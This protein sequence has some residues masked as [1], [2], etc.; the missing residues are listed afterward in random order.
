MSLLEQLKI[1]GRLVIPTGELTSQ[2]MLLIE[3][4]SENDFVETKKG[5]IQIVPLIGKEGWKDS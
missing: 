2:D 3:K 4:V 1:G 5:K